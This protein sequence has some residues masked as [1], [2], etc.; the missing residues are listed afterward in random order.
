MTL[1]EFRPKYRWDDDGDGDYLTRD[2]SGQVD[3]QPQ[4]AQADE[5]ARDRYGLTA[6]ELDEAVRG[7]KLDDDGG[8][9]AG[10]KQVIFG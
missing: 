5:I 7:Y 8:R 9:L 10:L 4:V 6:Y 1:G 2:E 3:T